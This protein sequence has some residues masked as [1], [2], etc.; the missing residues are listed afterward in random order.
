MYGSDGTTAVQTMDVFDAVFDV[1]SCILCEQ[2]ATDLSTVLRPEQLSTVRSQ[3]C[4]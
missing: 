2:V 1:L 4:S 3:A